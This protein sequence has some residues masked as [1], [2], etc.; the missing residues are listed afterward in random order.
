MMLMMLMKKRYFVY[1][2]LLQSVG[3]AMEPSQG[4][5]LEPAVNLLA[6]VNKKDDPPLTRAK[7]CII[8][9]E[10][11]N[12]KKHADKYVVLNCFPTHAF[13]KKCLRDACKH[14]K[15]K[16]ACPICRKLL[17]QADKLSCGIRLNEV[18]CCICQ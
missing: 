7:K 1:T 6:L 16:P 12:W 5:F 17:T 14:S 8:C 2:L 9:F 11:F 3:L 4:L 10:K 18:N 15:L 13:H